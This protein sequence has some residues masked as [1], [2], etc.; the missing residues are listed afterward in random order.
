MRGERCILGCRHGVLSYGLS[1]DWTQAV[2]ALVAR[3]RAATLR[4]NEMK[5]EEKETARA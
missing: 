4:H 2:S 1:I 3:R 5:R